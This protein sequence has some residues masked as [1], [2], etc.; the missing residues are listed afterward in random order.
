[1]RVKNPASLGVKSTGWC[2]KGGG[3]GVGGASGGK[4]RRAV[5][6]EDND[7]NNNGGRSS[8]IDTITTT[9]FT[10]DTTTA[11]TTT[12]SLNGG[13]GGGGNSSGGD[14]DVLSCGRCHHHHNNRCEDITDNLN[15]NKNNDA[16]SADVG[17]RQFKDMLWVVRHCIV[18]VSTSASVTVFRLDEEE[19]FDNLLYQMKRDCPSIASS[20][21]AVWKAILRNDAKGISRVLVD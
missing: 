11:T 6:E 10:T 5:G 21:D 15:L 1:M 14:T 12:A 4:K 3:G 7:I 20:S 8:G 2:L 18:A 17:P 16:L 19:L 13:K 9:T